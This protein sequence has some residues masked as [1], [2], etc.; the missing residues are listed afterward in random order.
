MT[1]TDV[2]TLFSPEAGAAKSQPAAN[3]S[4][5]G[6]TRWGG[7]G[8]THDRQIMRKPARP[9][10]ILVGNLYH[11]SVLV[12]RDLL[13]SGRICQDSAGRDGCSH[14]VSIGSQGHGSPTCAECLV[15]AAEQQP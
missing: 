9:V 3:S 13:G 1:G 14:F 5:A 6:Q 10:S 8:S 4:P 12:S 2:L 11:S 15:R 7:W